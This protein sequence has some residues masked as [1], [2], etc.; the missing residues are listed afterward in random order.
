VTRFTSVD[1]A[2]AEAVSGAVVE[3]VVARP[4][5]SRRRLEIAPQEEPAV[6]EGDGARAA[7]GLDFSGCG[8]A[9]WCMRC[10]GAPPTGAGGAVTLRSPT[11]PIGSTCVFA[12]R[13]V[14]IVK[15]NA[16]VLAREAG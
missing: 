1:D 14:V 16:I 2:A 10:G 13:A 11:A 4:F 3:C 5:L 12:G 6:L 8:A 15:S 7:R 9:F